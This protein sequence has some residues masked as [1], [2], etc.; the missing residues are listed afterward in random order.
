MSFVCSPDQA[1][2]E[3]GKSTSGVEW[4]KRFSQYKFAVLV[5]PPEHRAQLLSWYDVQIFDKATSSVAQSNAS[6]SE[7][8]FVTK[9]LADLISQLDKTDVHSESGPH[10]VSPGLASHFSPS[11]TSPFDI[12]PDVDIPMVHPD[13]LPSGPE[14]EERAVDAVLEENHQGISTTRGRPRATRVQTRKA[15]QRAT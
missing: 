12:I 15:K 9:D 5:L 11:P 7:P 6:S 8:V 10:S 3:R 4:G 13:I 14:P 2:T 1:F